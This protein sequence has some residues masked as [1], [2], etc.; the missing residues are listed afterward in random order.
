MIKSIVWFRSDLRISDNPALFQAAEIGKIFPVYIFDDSA[1]SEFKIGEFSKTYLY[2]SLKKLNESLDNR[3]NF[4]IGDAETILFDIIKKHK[5]ENIFWNEAFE[6]WQVEKDHSIKKKLN[7]Q[8]INYNI[9]N[10]S[11]LW[12]L[13][14]LLK[15]D[16]TYYK[17]FGAFKKKA[18]TLNRREITKTNH[19]LNFIKDL[20][21]EFSL[22]NLKN[23]LNDEIVE[24]VKKNW[25]IGEVAAQHKLI[26]FEKKLLKKYSVERDFPS[27]NHTS[28]LSPHLH[29]GEISPVQIW[30]E[31]IKHQ[32][33][34]PQEDVDHFLSELIWRDFSCYLLI[35]FN[36]LHYQ[37][38]QTKFDN[39]P[40]AYDKNLFK[41]WTDGMTGYPIVDAGMRELL[42]TGTMHNRVRMITASF[43]I[44]NLNIHWHAGRDW[45]W[46]HL[47]DADLASN[48]FNWQ[49]V[50][51]SGTD[52]SPFFRIFN[53]VTQGTKFDKN[54][55]YTKKFVPELANLSP[56]YLF[57]PW[58][59]PKEELFNAKI[60]L[61]KDY[62]YPIIDL[63]K[64]RDQALKNY[65]KL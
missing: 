28:N 27:K 24:K 23:I 7:Q 37:N 53:P 14:N 65:K 60:V 42:Q 17:I 51:G 48:S 61:G 49:W 32:Q 50:A 44:K 5:I 29:F 21:N 56:K 22:N 18:L 52:A 31:I 40:W 20:S 13:K 4:Y 58:T 33:K 25:D 47:V 43:L 6:P 2:F 63:K 12:D 15:N 41:A 62:P 34:H 36:K 16:Q 46:N 59:A 39:F 3:L 35:H 8:N 10:G 54:G 38:F 57:E 1:P 19:N 64:S 45:F 9:F 26:N 30:N 11:Y 55:E